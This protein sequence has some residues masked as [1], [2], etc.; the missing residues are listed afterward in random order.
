MVRRAVVLWQVCALSF[1]MCTKHNLLNLDH[2]CGSG[3]GDSLL[4]KVAPQSELANVCAF[5]L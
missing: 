5:R 1:L 2:S 4:A 3:C